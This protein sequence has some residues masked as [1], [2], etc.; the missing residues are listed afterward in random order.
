[1]TIDNQVGLDGQ[2]MVAPIDGTIGGGALGNG[3]G[4]SESTPQFGSGQPLTNPSMWRC[5]RRIDARKVGGNGFKTWQQKMLFFLTNLNLDKYLKDDA[6]IVPP[7]N[8]DSTIMD[9][10]TQSD[11]LCK[12][13]ILSRLIDPLYNVYCEAKTSK[14]LWLA[15]EKKYKSE[16]A[17]CQ[18]Y[19]TAKFLNF[20]MVDS[21]PIMEQVEALQLITHEIALRAHLTEDDLCAVVTEV[22]NVEDNPREWWYDTG[23]TIHI[24]NDMDMFS[25]Y[26]KCNNGERLLMGNTGSSK[27]EGH[28]KVVLKMTSGKE[29]TLQNVKHVTDMRKNLISG[30]LMSKAGFATNF[31]S[32]KLVLKKHE[33]IWERV[34]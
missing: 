24:C 33:F 31:E 11:F 18:K 22:N 30:T 20:K 26:Q 27:I 23:A 4:L 14:Q 34:C 17:G 25:T 10:W 13:W 12:G 3:N 16:D 9:R 19:A 28:G 2:N 21:K 7:G 29:I 1:M 32:D 15:L 6:P 8:T 5:K